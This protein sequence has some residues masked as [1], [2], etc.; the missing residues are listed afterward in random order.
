MNQPTSNTNSSEAVKVKLA[1][2]RTVLGDVVIGTD[3][4]R[5]VV[6]QV[7]LRDQVQDGGST[8][9][10]ARRDSFGPYSILM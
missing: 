6:R 10:V 9:G 7:L 2:G 5:S 1:D 4:E 3:G 8:E